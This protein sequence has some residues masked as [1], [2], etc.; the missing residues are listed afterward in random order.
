MKRVYSCQDITLGLPL[1]LSESDSWFHHED[2]LNQLLSTLDPL[3]LTLEEASS[4]AETP[5]DI[6]P[7][8]WIYEWLRYIVYDI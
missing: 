8:L 5:S 7:N 3:N 4:L 6:D 1:D 2:R